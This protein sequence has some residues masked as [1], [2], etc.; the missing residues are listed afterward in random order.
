MLKYTAYPTAQL[1]KFKP[2]S[3]GLNS[4]DICFYDSKGCMHGGKEWS[5]YFGEHCGRYIWD[6]CK[7]SFSLHE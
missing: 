1:R 3:Q 7:Y 2:M 4:D 5:F 6:N